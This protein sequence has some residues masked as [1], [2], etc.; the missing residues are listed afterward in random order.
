MTSTRTPKLRVYGAL[1]AVQV[2][3]G[4]NYLAAK[5]VLREL[6]PQALAVL[7]IVGAALV[8]WVTTRFAGVRLP[9]APADVARLPCTPSSASS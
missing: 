3:F 7:R 5:V 2:F 1:V 6:E 9:T 4:L 8:L